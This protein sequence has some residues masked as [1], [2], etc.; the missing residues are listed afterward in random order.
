M[1]GWV[2]CVIIVVLLEQDGRHSI[3][4]SAESLAY[5]MDVTLR[6]G[7]A[8][9]DERFVIERRCRGVRRARV[10]GH[11][12]CFPI[13]TK[14]QTALPSSRALCYVIETR[15]TEAAIQCE[16]LDRRLCCLLRNK[17]SEQAKD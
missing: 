15:L 16:R 11:E 7:I 2:P 1:R 17:N 9:V 5:R 10:Y 14:F 12:A 3:A 13:W 4:I 6:V 8:R